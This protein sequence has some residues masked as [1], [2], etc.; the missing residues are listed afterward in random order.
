VDLGDI[1][2]AVAYPGAALG[3]LDQTEL[4]HVHVQPKR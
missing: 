2:R 4:G 1:R 3:V